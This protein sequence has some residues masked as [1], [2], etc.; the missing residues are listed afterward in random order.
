MHGAKLSQEEY[1]PI[2]QGFLDCIGKEGCYTVS[3]SHHLRC[4]LIVGYVL[5]LQ[6]CCQVECCSGC[7]LCPGYYL[8]PGIYLTIDVRFQSRLHRIRCLHANAVTILPSQTDFAA[9][10]R[11]TGR[12]QCF[13]ALIMA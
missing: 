4:L 7:R 3:P 9:A 8:C 6:L 2:K 5:S 12:I 11:R 10:L 1:N 13:G